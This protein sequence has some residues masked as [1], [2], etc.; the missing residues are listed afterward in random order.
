[1]VNPTRPSKPTES[2]LEILQVLWQKEKATVRQVHEDLSA[3]KDAGYTTTIKLMQIMHEKGLVK[4][5][6]TAKTHIYEPLVSKE[7]TQQHFLGKM[8]ST[9]FDGSASQLV[10]RALGGSS[11]SKAEIDEIQKILD[12]LK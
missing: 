6:E 1:M 4:R 10:M 11:P 5:N 7:N 8:M 2:E 3:T 12:G 9:L